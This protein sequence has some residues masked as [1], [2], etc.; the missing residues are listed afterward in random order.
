M[1][2]AEIGTLKSGTDPYSAEAAASSTTK[3]ESQSAEESDGTPRTLPISVWVPD[4]QVF[5]INSRILVGGL[6]EPARL[7]PLHFSD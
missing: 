5:H 4:I 3:T 1:P 6:V 2:L 7:V